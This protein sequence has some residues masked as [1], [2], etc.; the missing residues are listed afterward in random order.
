VADPSDPPLQKA[1]L[2]S[3]VV[4]Y[5]DEGPRDAPAVLAVHGIPGS[6]RDFRYLAPEAAG[7][8]RFVRPDL[9]GFGGSDATDGAVT[10]LAGRARSIVD[11]A[12]HL[13]LASFAILGHSMGGATALT[14]ASRHRA[15]VRLLALVASVGLSQ[16]RGLGMR[17]G[18]FKLIAHGL[19]A[20]LVSAA[21][22]RFARQQYAQRRFP[23]ADQMTAREFAVQFRAIGALDFG[24]LRRAVAAPLPPAL[25][26]YAD[27]DPLVEPA[28]AEEMLATVPGSRGLRF[29]EGG[30]NLQ[31][32]RAAEIAAALCRELLPEGAPSRGSDH[33]GR[34]AP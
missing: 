30:H 19:R 26:V 16:H 11:L 5:V 23:G 7:R 28:I 10:T 25:V 18:I 17:P 12:D 31:K 6:H 13:G 24:L 34:S 29:E 9:P 21:L 15:R 20:P 3:G 33:G 27:D 4:A 1:A 14:L 2:S 32:T 22:L 8:L